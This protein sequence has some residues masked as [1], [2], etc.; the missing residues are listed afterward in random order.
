MF[1]SHKYINNLYHQKPSDPR[2]FLSVICQSISLKA[3]IDTGAE[4]TL[5][6]FK[7]YNQLASKPTLK[8]T[9][10]TLVTANGGY[11]ETH[12][13]CVLSFQLDQEKTIT[14]PVIIVSNLGT[15]LTIGADTIK[16]EEMDVNMK[17][18]KVTCMKN[19]FPVVTTS[20]VTIQPYTEKL[21][22]YA[23][24]HTQSKGTFLVSPTVIQPLFQQNINGP[25][26][27]LVIGNATDQP[28]HLKR[29]TPI[30]TACPIPLKDIL[31]DIPKD[32][33]QKG[34]NKV[35]KQSVIEDMLQQVDFGNIPKHYQPQFRDR[36]SVV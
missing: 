14:R 32:V 23:V 21:V 2:P 4:C 36:K 8:E 33:A 16:D 9:L 22:P 10:F 29:N 20:A 15:P 7:I 3:L 27:V 13:S 5:L 30:G 18:K 25:N 12:G 24:S 1:N 11:L 26:S 28:L 17:T 34:I 35:E 19:P 31:I 6:D